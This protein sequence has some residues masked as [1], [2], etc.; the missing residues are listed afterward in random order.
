MMKVEWMFYFKG[1][2]LGWNTVF[3]STYEEACEEADRVYIPMNLYPE[4]STVKKVSENEDEYKRL[5]AWFW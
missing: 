2:N 5:L 3:A 4:H 1:T